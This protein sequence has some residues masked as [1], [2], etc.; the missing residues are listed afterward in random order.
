MWLYF[1]PQALGNEHAT[2]FSESDAFTESKCDG[3]SDSDLSDGVASKRSSVNIEGKKRDRS[4]GTKQIG[5]HMYI[6][7]FSLSHFL[8]CNGLHL[9]VKPC[10]VRLSKIHRKKN[11]HLLYICII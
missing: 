5:S 2:L 1:L 7:T 3:A 8:E 11:N 4:L 9:T 10:E 6:Y